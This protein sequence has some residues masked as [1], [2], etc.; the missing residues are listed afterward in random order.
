MNSAF[1]SIDSWCSGRDPGCF[2]ACNLRLHPLRFTWFTKAITAIRVQSSSHLPNEKNNMELPK[3]TCNWNSDNHRFT[4]PPWSFG[5][6]LCNRSEAELQEC[7]ETEL[8][9]EQQQELWQLE[10][11]IGSLG[12]VWKTLTIHGT[13]GI[14]TYNDWLIFVVNVGKYSIHGSY[15]QQWCVCCVFVVFISCAHAA[16]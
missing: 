7:F 2:A 13:N 11:P 5:F 10:V 4:Q 6:Q 12:D 8:S 9:E 14:F 16:D 1:S 15:G 3:S